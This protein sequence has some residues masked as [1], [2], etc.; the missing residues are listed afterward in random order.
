M[1]CIVPVPIRNFASTCGPGVEMRPGQWKERFA[2]NALRS[3]INDALARL[4]PAPPVAARPRK[5]H[6]AQPVFGY[7]DRQPSGWQGIA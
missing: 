2:R 5:R 4:A 7:V 1:P 6:L 3:D